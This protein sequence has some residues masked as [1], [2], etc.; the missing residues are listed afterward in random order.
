MPLLSLSGLRRAALLTL[1]TVPCASASP[2]TD[3]YRAA[4]SSVL[5]DYYGWSTAD[6]RTLSEQYG[7]TLEERCAPAADT[8]SFD[9]AREVLTSLFREVGDAHTNVRDPEGALRLREVQENR[10]V[11]RTGARVVRVEGG[12]LVASVMPGS[13]AA[14]AGLRPLDLLPSVNGQPAGRRD[15]DNAPVGPTEFTRL[16]RAGQPFEVEVRRAGQPPHPLTLSS[17]PLTARDEPTLTWA[18]PDSRTAVV[19]VASFLPADTAEQ[20]LARVQQAAQAGARALVVDLR[21]NG[22]G[23]LTQCVAAASVFAPVEYRARSR[24]GGAVYAGAGGRPARPL[25]P[26]PQEA[27]VW[28]GPAAVLVGPNTASC[29][30]VFTYYAQRAGALAVGEATRGVGN[31]GVTFQ[32]LPDG[33]VLS[34]TM[35]RAYWPDGTPLPER[36]QPDLLAPTDLQ[37]LTGEGRDTTLQAALEALTGRTGRAP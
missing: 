7:R 29:S 13:P 30:E 8:C 11:L 37:A 35:L 5:R 6:L 19:T 4:T 14:R 2:A 12:L 21:F 25:D 17:E 31:S 18:G 23:S 33:G 10:A 34:V 20:F 24:T 3:L 36:V 28:S 15:G 9:T 1:L 32:P 27:A 22:G 26:H 16:E